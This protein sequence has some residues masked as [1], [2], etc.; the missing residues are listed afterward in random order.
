MKD[1][2]PLL[3]RT[4]LSFIFLSSGWGKLGEGF[5]PTQQYME[6]NGMSATAFWLT[7]GIILELVG[8]V[9]AILGVYA[10]FGAVMLIAFM[11]P[12]T[13]I[14]HFDPGNRTEMIAFMKNWSVVGGLILLAYYGAGQLA[15]DRL[16]R[17]KQ[18]G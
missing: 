16:W 5:A 9:M 2:I 3:G 6:A 4:L 18:R 8:G 13:F 7:I 15:V 12:V 14:F 17:R 10:R 11:V 1:L